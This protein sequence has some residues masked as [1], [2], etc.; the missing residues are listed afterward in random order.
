MF[1]APKAIRCWQVSHFAAIFRAGVLDCFVIL[2]QGKSMRCL[3]R[4]QETNCLK[5]YL[6]IPHS[7]PFA[8]GQRGAK[9]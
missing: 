1:A 9:F 7:R 3:T 2:D 4:F 5:L 6:S 8:N